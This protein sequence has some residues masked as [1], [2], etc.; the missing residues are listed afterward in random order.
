MS[1]SV[2][3][4]TSDFC[5]AGIG[6][7]REREE[8]SR[9]SLQGRLGIRKGA[10][11]GRRQREQGGGQRGAESLGDKGVLGRNRERD[12]GRKQRKGTGRGAGGREGMRREAEMR[13]LRELEKEEGGNRGEERGRGRKVEA[14]RVSKTG[15][16]G[17]ERIL[18][19]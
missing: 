18:G 9:R 1:S 5:T 17:K 11:R 8:G 16:Q 19:G 6:G 3:C 2:H 4:V 13:G 15:P 14:E 10:A 7:G 12:A